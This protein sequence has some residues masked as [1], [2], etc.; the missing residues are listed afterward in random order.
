MRA[1]TAVDIEN[2]EMLRKLEEIQKQLDYGFNLVSKEKMHITL[3]FF[4][5]VNKE[6]VEKIIEAMEKVDQAPFQVRIQGAGVFP[7]REH[8]RVVW[9]GVDS[10]KI[11]DLKNQA[12]QH[13]VESSNNHEF[14]PHITL[15]R[16]RSI[17]PRKKGN[18]LRT[19]EGM[20]NKSIGDLE[21]HSFK[22]FESVRTGNGTHYR[23]LKEVE[24]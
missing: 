16:V 24:S 12:S 21:I 18:F 17:S 15:A 22:L 10:D 3:Q 5:D 20:E 11:F 6:E 4:Q 2:R 1:F 13:P 7:S 23:E 19:L 9:A 8:I 14:H